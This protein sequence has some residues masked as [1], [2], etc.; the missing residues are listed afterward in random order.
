MTVD[1]VNR[2][3]HNID[4]YA[5]QNTNSSLLQAMLF[6]IP[7][8]Q[9]HLFIMTGQ[10][11]ARPALQVQLQPLPA[12]PNN[13]CCH[14]CHLLR[15]VVLQGLGSK[16]AQELW[17]HEAGTVPRAGTL[18][19]TLKA[20]VPSRDMG[21]TT[22]IHP[23]AQSNCIKMVVRHVLQCIYAR[24]TCM[25]RWSS[26]FWSLSF[27]KSFK[28][29]FWILKVHFWFQSASSKCTLILL[30][31][32]FFVVARGSASL[33]LSTNGR[34]HFQTHEEPLNDVEA[35]SILKVHFEIPKCHFEL[36]KV[37]LKVCMKCV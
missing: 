4:Y 23:C 37:P 34:G 16:R 29:R 25:R 32:R 27:L 24:E 17:E 20:K 14:V 35:L 12:L 10:E 28:V 8:T 9:I 13:S 33:M 36:F 22:D 3:V 21:L 26:V 11:G 15:E 6:S 2:K 5:R 1:G 19:G 18:I 30:I 7:G 31:C